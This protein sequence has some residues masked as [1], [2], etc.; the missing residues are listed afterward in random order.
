MGAR[1]EAGGEQVTFFVSDTGIGIAEE[2]QQV[3]F[4]EFGQVQNHLQPRVK[5]TGLGLPLCR[6]LAA[7]LGGYT[8]VDSAPGVGSTFY[9][10]LPVKAEAVAASGADGAAG[11][12]GIAH[13]GAS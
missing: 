13:R 4:E 1:L 6:K 10:T 8:G 2:H 5:G 9:A 7:L 12:A 11:G 3:I